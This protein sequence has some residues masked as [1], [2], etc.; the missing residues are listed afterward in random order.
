MN[1]LIPLFQKLLVWVGSR[2]LLALGISLITYTG[3][4]LSLNTLKNYF[5]NS[6]NSIP[7]DVFNL[8]MMAGLGQAIG[9]IFGAF[10]FKAAMASASKLQAG[11]MNKM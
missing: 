2:V 9:I 4:T 1:A 11:I 5:M 10:A 7:S 8:L 6:V 3:I